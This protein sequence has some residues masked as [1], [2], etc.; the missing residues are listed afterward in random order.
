MTQAKEIRAKYKNRRITLK[1]IAQNYNVSFGIIQRITS[2]KG[3][4]EEGYNV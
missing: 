2:N 4:L 3:Y 1:K